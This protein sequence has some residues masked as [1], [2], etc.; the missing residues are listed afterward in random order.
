MSDKATAI[1]LLEQIRPFAPRR[2][3]LQSWDSAAKVLRYGCGDES[4]AVVVGSDGSLEV[5]A[6]GAVSRLGSSTVKRFLEG[7]EVVSPFSAI[8][9]LL[10]E[11]IY[12][13]DDRLYALFSAW[14]CGTYLYSMFSHYGYLFLFSS[15]P[16]CG[17]TRAEEVVS[18]L[19]FEATEPRNAPTAPSMRETAVAGGTAIF[20]TLERWS[21]KSTE[22]FAAAMELLDAGFRRNG[23]V[24]KMVASGGGEWRQ[25]VFPV[26]AP[27]MFA[28]INRSSLSETALD[29]SF[30]VGMRR[31]STKLRTK[32]FD[33]QCEQACSPLRDQMYLFALAHA[34]KVLEAYE[35]ETLQQR[36][37]SLGLNDRA[38]DIWKPLLAV[39][40]VMHPDSLDALSQLAVAMSPD[41]DRQEEFRQL[42]IV[43]ALR[44]MA[45][46][47]GSLVGTSQQLISQLATLADVGEVGDL[48]S[49]FREWGFEDKSLRL[50]G[51]DTPRKGWEI[52]EAQLAAVDARLRADGIPSDTST[53][54]T[55]CESEWDDQFEERV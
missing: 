37:N 33:A 38:S 14:I 51:I 34:S 8:R 47:G 12:L 41:A 39:S 44:G 35:S 24:T 21:K 36:M 46:E 20:D 7:G 23:T 28:A 22:S 43:T 9:D 18:L 10:T 25:E 31:K 55:T 16:R 5:Q 48:T 49:L 13:P 3:F 53:T 15:E 6:K 40:T 27:Y 32:P 45:G 1:Q 4:N 17:K 54:E 2:R 26:Y 19:A 29:R 52:T 42:R 11:Y 50:T 30:E